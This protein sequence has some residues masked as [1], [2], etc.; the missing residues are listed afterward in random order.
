M[1]P[2]QILKSQII[3]ELFDIPIHVYTIFLCFLN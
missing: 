1:C 2:E 3:D